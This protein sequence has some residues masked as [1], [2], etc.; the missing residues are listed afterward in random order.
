[1]SIAHCAERPPCVRLR[2][3]SAHC[4]I[5]KYQNVGIEGADIVHGSLPGWPLTGGRDKLPADAC[6]G[7]GE[8]GSRRDQCQTVWATSADNS[9]M[10]SLRHR[11]RQQCLD[12]ACQRLRPTLA[13]Q[14]AAEYTECV[15]NV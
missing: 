6:E 4:R 10:C 7:F 14:N 5:G 13:V 12:E 1:M 3:R 8:I 11:Q 9:Q 15:G 2:K